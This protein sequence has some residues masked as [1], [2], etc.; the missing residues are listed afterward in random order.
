MNKEI[1]KIKKGLSSLVSKQE[2]RRLRYYYNDSIYNR[3]FLFIDNI[4]KSKE[5]N[6]SP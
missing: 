5:I 2:N 3:N 1:Y 4:I 6:E